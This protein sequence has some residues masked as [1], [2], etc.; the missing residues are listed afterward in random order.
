MIAQGPGLMM[1]GPSAVFWQS[2]DPVNNV[3]FSANVDDNG[4]MVSLSPGGGARESDQ[5]QTFG[6]AFATGGRGAHIGPD[7]NAPNGL[8]SQAS[9]KV[10]QDKLVVVNAGSDTASLYQIDFENPAL[11][12]MIGQPVATMGNFPV[13]ATIDPG[14]RNVCIL[15]GCVLSREYVVAP[16]MRVARTAA[17]R[18]V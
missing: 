17:R 2:N 3:V 8:A 16:L 12:R 10:V 13:S 1:G 18:T 15:N 7:V 5:E 6:G 4:M 14:S 11:I 9:V